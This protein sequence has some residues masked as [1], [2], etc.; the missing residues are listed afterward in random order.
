MLSH[1]ATIGIFLLLTVCF[2]VGA[3]VAAWML[4]AK[5]KVDPDDKKLVPYDGKLDKD[6]INS[7]KRPYFLS[8][9]PKA[10]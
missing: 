5:P 3:M 6:I 10:G 2:P 1:S 9:I 4:R 7:R 8:E